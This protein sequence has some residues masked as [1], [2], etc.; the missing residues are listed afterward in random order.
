MVGHPWHYRGLMD[1]IAGNLAG[2]LLDVKTWANEG[3]IDAAIPAGYYREGGSAEAAY[4]A[5]AEETQGKCDLWYYAWVPN[6]V[7]E[8]E[9]QFASAQS[10]GAKR[11][12]HWEA[13][14]ID[15]RPQAADLKAAMHAKAK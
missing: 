9:T 2:L 1:P 13:D 4:K 7:E 15:D 10:L 3:L 6:T 12:L 11:I 8:F 14:Y 5:L